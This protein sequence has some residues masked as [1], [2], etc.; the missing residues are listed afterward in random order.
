MPEERS[1]RKGNRVQYINISDLDNSRALEAYSI[2]SYKIYKSYKI[3]SSK[4]SRAQYKIQRFDSRTSEYLTDEIWEIKVIIVFMTSYN[5]DQDYCRANKAYMIQSYF[6]TVEHGEIKILNYVQ[7][8]LL[9]CFGHKMIAIWD[10]PE[11]SKLIE[12]I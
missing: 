11:H 6:L 8:T 1:Y 7:L 12:V 5:S 2:W 3:Y 10:I 9:S 4:P